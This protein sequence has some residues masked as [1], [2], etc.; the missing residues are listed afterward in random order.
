MTKKKLL[1]RLRKYRLPNEACRS[2]ATKI[3]YLLRGVPDSENIDIVAVNE[4]G[5][6]SEY[7]ESQLEA[8]DLEIELSGLFS[9]IETWVDSRSSGKGGTVNKKAR[10][11]SRFMVVFLVIIAVMVVGTAIL[12]VLDVLGKFKYGNE[13]SIALDGVGLITGL[14]FFAYERISDKKKENDDDK[15]DDNDGGSGSGGSSSGDVYSPTVIALGNHAQAAGRDI[16]N[17]SK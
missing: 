13:L 3:E 12:V 8:R 11:K 2:Y 5:K 6:R 1:G 17:G 4:F 14:I 15:D 9:A 16:H 10:K 7:I